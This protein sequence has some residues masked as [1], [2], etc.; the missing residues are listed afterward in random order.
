M[1]DTRKVLFQANP[2]AGVLTDGY[3][4][5]ALT[6]VVVSSLAAANRSEYSAEFR[7][8]IAVS[9]GADD[10]KQYLYYDAEIAGHDTFIAT[11]GI[12]LAATDV[13]RVYSSNGNVSFQ[14][15]GLES[16]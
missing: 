3:T 2:D 14:A 8:A 9:G 6:S 4:V 11:I 16:T 7:V 15:F 10:P 5:P 12:T 13:I 1:T